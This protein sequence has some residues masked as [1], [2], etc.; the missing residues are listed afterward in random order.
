[1]RIIQ[2]PLTLLILTLQG[3]TFIST[4]EKGD[5]VFT[6]EQLTATPIHPIANELGDTVIEIPRTSVDTSIDIIRQPE[7]DGAITTRIQTH[8][9]TFLKI[10]L[11]EP[12]LLQQIV[13]TFSQF[14]QTQG[15]LPPSSS[16]QITYPIRHLWFSQM[17]YFAESHIELLRSIGNRIPHRIDFKL[18]QEQPTFISTLK[19]SIA[20]FSNCLKEDKP[21]YQGKTPVLFVHGYTPALKGLGGG[22]ETW[23]N[24][25]SRILDLKNTINHGQQKSE[26]VVFEFRWA[27]SARF[28]EASADLGK[29][30]EKIA[31]A[32][33]KTVHVVAHSFGGLLVRTYLQGLA[34]NF[35]YRKNI[36]S[37]TT[38]GTPHSGLTEEDKVMHGVFFNRGQDVQ[39]LVTGKM[40][41]NFCQQISCYQLGEYVDFTEEEL[42]LFQLNWKDKNKLTPVGTQDAFIF[43]VPDQLGLKDKPGKLI[44]IL[45]DTKNHPL[46]KNLPMQILIGLTVE[47]FTLPNQFLAKI[48]EGDGLISY[49]AQRLL[50][51]MTLGYLNPLL[52]KEN[53][54]GGQV[55]EKILGFNYDVRP[56]EISALPKTDPDYWGYRHTNA[57][58]DV[59]FKSKAMVQV[60]CKH[61]T[62]C[63]H[64]TFNMVKEW[65]KEYPSTPYVSKTALVTGTINVMNAQTHQPVP[66]AYV[67]IYQYYPLQEELVSLSQTD[68]Q[69]QTTFEMEIKPNT[70]Y[71][72]DV[73]AWG[74]EGVSKVNSMKMGTLDRKQPFNFG[75]V[76]LHPKPE[77]GTLEGV[78]ID[79]RSGQ[80][81]ERTNYV[82]HTGDLWW[83]GH[84]DTKGEYVI[85]G[86]IEG[87]VELFFFKEDYRME[88]LSFHMQPSE[89]KVTDVLLEK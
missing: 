85:T 52:I 63:D 24:F 33:G 37:V 68:K 70:T 75:V 40:K 57:A 50:P 6:A 14:E 29:A 10:T 47:Q 81:I 82:V 80:P 51:S 1:M 84:A 39:G 22:E 71:F 73:K 83:A 72:A 32:T 12:E 3:C 76:K 16:E 64:A 11:P 21:C 67:R 27:T 54:F 5:K 23:K 7:N 79:A 18:T 69:G 87:N 30:I 55:T 15:R 36:A 46:P 28:E 61:S 43:D 58:I 8:R 45:S 66:F 44:S 74:F 88:K 53:R 13:P 86:L 48:Q 26:Y 19:D 62:S 38:V 49:A 65:I 34:T 56:G 31:Q 60:D 42:D 59:N 41:I 77:R 89:R 4:F 35:P 17:A 20:L 9:P 78:V 2:L 25:P